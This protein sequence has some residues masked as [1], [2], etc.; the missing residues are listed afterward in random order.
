MSYEMAILTYST[1]NVAL[2]GIVSYFL[3]QKYRKLVRVTGQVIGNSRGRGTLAGGHEREGQE[4][5][6]RRQQSYLR[7]CFL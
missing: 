7:L 1:S 6:R 3:V 2:C 4:V 5:E